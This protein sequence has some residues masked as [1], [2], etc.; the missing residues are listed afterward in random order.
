MEPTIF[1]LPTDNGAKD[2]IHAHLTNTLADVKQ[3]LYITTK[4]KLARHSLRQDAD[5]VS[6]PENKGRATVI[7]NQTDYNYKASTLLNN[8]NAHR[9]VEENPHQDYHMTSQ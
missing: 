5:I 7:L 2:R 3:H 1:T 4:E 8:E 6:V 9:K